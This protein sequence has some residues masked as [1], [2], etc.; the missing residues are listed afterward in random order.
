M[1]I[2][3]AGTTVQAAAV[4][5]HLHNTQ[6]SVVAV[7]TREDAPVGRKAIV[8]P[9]AV[10]QL[11]EELSLP[12]IK[13][14]RISDEVVSQLDGYQPD[15][16]VVIAYGS[17]LKA[18]ALAVPAHGW[19]NLHFSLLPKWRGAA[20]VQHS[21]LAGDPI[22]GVSIFRL[23]EGMDTGPLLA[24]VPT[25]VQPD[26]NAG[27]LL[28]R[29][30]QIGISALDESLARIDAGI[31]VFEPQTGI[32][33]VAGKL[34]RSDAKIDWSLNAECINNLVRAMN[35]EPIAWTTFGESTMRVLSSRPS[36]QISELHRGTV[37]M[38]NNQAYVTCGSNS[39]LQLIQVQPAGKNS[40]SAADWLRGQSES[41][42]LGG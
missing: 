1:K 37:F 14:N 41:V 21:L 26:E 5:K 2:V 3:F 13:A 28:N 15:L 10:A 42:V 11:A 40:M 12:I 29:L 39:V 17:L 19:I 4:L 36:R 24:S 25:E 9:S 16:G 18:P 34:Q 27:E 35:P 33:T 22:T 32:A 20:P 30:T 7:L 6:H 8:T 31:A 38:E 23:D